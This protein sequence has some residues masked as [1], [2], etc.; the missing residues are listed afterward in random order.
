MNCPDGRRLRMMAL[1][2]DAGFG[3]MEGSGV[4]LEWMA[5]LSS[6]CPL[7]CSLCSEAEFHLLGLLVLTQCCEFSQWCALMI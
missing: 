2:G 7:P 6:H 3:L 4:S 5:N 1:Q